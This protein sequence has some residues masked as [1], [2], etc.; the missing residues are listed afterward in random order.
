VL[1]FGN[2]RL[3]PC[4]LARNLKNV[5]Y[6]SGFEKSLERDP[7]KQLIVP[8]RLAGVPRFHSLL[9]SS[10]SQRRPLAHMRNP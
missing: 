5:L 6:R 9:K 7:K 2:E 8:V 3:T 4:P 1:F 10:G